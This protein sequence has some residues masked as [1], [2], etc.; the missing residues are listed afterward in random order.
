MGG[1]LV[2]RVV[3]VTRA[4]AYEALI[5][6]HGTRQ[7]ASFFLSTRGQ[8]I[9]PLA[10]AHRRFDEAVQQVHRAIPTKWRRT[11]LA[12]Q[13][14][15]RFLFGPEDVIVAV[16]QD[17]LVANVA[18]YLDGQAVIGVNPDPE[19]YD[20]I[21]VPHPPAA[22]AELLRATPAGRIRCEERTMVEAHLDDGQRLV[23]LNE[24]FVGHRTHQSAR[25]RI[26]W[27][28]AEERHSSSGLIVATGTGATG[29]ARSIHQQRRSRVSLPRP[30]DASLVFFVREPFPSVATGNAVT[31][32]RVDTGHPLAVFSEMNACGVVFGDGI[33]DDYLKFDWGRRIAVRPADRSLRLVRG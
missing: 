13:E 27:G 32:G 24:V 33:E 2:P 1:R 25:Y 29:W 9:E 22:A 28:G 21:L 16:G 7:Q 6:E 8:S 23:A 31:E 19:L 10:A 11:R 15:D 5:A 20:G 17:G 12:R 18:K 30:S 4:T 3:V 26:V 14:L